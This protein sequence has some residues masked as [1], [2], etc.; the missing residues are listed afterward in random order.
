[1]KITN[2]VTQ[3]KKNLKTCILYFKNVSNLESLI[4]DEYS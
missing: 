1:M 3:I 2:N 4:I